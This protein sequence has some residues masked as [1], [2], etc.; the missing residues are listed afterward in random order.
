MPAPAKKKK[1]RYNAEEEAVKRIAKNIQAISRSFI[2]GEYY[3]ITDNQ[4]L[5]NPIL[6]YE[7]KEGIHHVFSE[8]HGKWIVIEYSCYGVPDFVL[9]N[10]DSILSACSSAGL[11]FRQLAELSNVD[12]DIISKYR[13]HE[14]WP[15]RSRY[16]RLAKILGW[17]KWKKERN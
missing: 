11:T 4:E 2:E 1:T 6:R 9:V 15:C 16:N 8:I 10:I 17:R 3:I 12:M 14:K 5:Q 13:Q 7:R